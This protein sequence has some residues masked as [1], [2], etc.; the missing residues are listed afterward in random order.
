MKKREF[1]YGHAT[2]KLRVCDTETTHFLLLEQRQWH[3]IQNKGFENTDANLIEPL[4]EHVLRKHRSLPEVTRL[5][6]APENNIIA[7]KY[8]IFFTYHALPSQYKPK[9]VATR[10]PCF[11]IS[12]SY[13]QHFVLP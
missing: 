6:K 4:A 12:F 8:Y 1:K 10:L 2:T 3:K 7:P 5:N 11:P 9:T 13:R